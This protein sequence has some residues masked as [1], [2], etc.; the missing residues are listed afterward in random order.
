MALKAG[1]C[2]H[3]AIKPTLAARYKY[4]TKQFVN[5]APKKADSITDTRLRKTWWCNMNSL[6]LC[7]ASSEQNYQVLV[8]QISGCNDSF[9]TGIYLLLGTSK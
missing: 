1:R 6:G 2:H 7:S 8:R 3:A 9:I 5:V 4:N